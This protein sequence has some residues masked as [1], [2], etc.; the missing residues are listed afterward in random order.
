MATARIPVAWS[1]SAPC[2]AVEAGDGGVYLDARSL[3]EADPQ[4]DGL[5]HLEPAEARVLAAVL[6]HFAQEAE[7]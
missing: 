3:L 7:A 1:P 6:Q 4:W 2:I 5:V